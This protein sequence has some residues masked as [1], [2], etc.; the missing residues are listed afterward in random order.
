M[1]DGYSPL[2][3]LLFLAFVVLE[4]AFYGFGAAIQNVS[5][6]ELERE[7]ELGN[8]KAQK[9][10]KIV[11][12]PSQFINSIQIVTN[13][14]GIVLGAYVL[15]QW[16]GQLKA[17]LGQN[18]IMEGTLLHMISLLAA[19]ALILVILICFG[20][21]I[22]KRC[23]AKNPERWGYGLYPFISAAIVPMVPFIAIV[24]GLSAA[25]LRLI[26]VDL[27]ADS[28]NVTEEDIM[29]MVN[30]GHEQGV[31]EATE[32]E[33]IT[34]IFELNDKEAGDI[35]THRINVEAI[36]GEMSLKEAI[37]FILKEG[38]NS[39][40]P[41]YEDNIDNIV[42][43]LHMKD[44]LIYAENEGDTDCQISKIPG[45]LREAH[46][47]PETRNIDDLFKEMQSQKIHMEIVVD[48]YGQMAGIV[49]MEDI[50]EEI[51]GNILDEYDAE[52]EFIVTAEEGFI[53]DGLAPL[54]EV[55]EALEITFAEED[56]ESFDTLNGFLVSKL[57]RIPQEG[58]DLEVEY[59]GYQFK[60][61][62]LE[63]RVIRSVKALKLWE[64]AEAGDGEPAGDETPKE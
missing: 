64:T 34:N 55:E 20:I 24:T 45:L 27:N 18:Q 46:F 35:M 9:L 11:N 48:E 31:L 14:I 28:E 13:V 57:G 51:V 62:S 26:G 49:T 61:L 47:I 1:D 5:A 25:V 10:L 44:A 38:K 53:L 50:L 43:I 17:V 36:D 52:E 39:R 63:N 3:I 56:H 4:A 54:E 60:V 29:S 32:A 19:A 12:R 21:I 33:M 22:P 30:E 7:M 58:D 16:T 42:G 8:K 40:Y 59:E 15:E 37:G 2:S 23:A 41:V 6:N